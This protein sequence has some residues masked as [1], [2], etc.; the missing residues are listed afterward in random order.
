MRWPTGD[1]ASNQRNSLIKNNYEL[2][3]KE[4]KLTGGACGGCAYGIA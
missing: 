3:K 1:L 2:E 4:T